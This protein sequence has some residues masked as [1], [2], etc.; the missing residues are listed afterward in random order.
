MSRVKKSQKGCNLDK[1]SRK[2]GFDPKV[3]NPKMGLPITPRQFLKR[4]S[5]FPIIDPTRGQIYEKDSENIFKN[6]GFQH[7]QV[8]F[9]L[10]VP[11]G[12]FFPRNISFS[13]D[14]LSMFLCFPRS[15]HL[16]EAVPLVM[17]KL[18]HACHHITRVKSA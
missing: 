7:L 5:L 17:T 18:C 11:N 9:T 2:S 13:F 16:A 8:L 4:P 6:V 12:I 10:V 3:K 14:V 15:L 1:Q